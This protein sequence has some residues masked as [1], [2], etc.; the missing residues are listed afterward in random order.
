MGR[1]LGWRC[2]SPDDRLVLAIGARLAIGISPLVLFL[3]AVY[4]GQLGPAWLFPAARDHGGCLVGDA[5]QRAGSSGSSIW[6]QRAGRANDTESC[7]FAANRLHHGAKRSCDGS[8]GGRRAAVQYLITGN[9]NGPNWPGLGRPPLP[10]SPLDRV[11]ERD[12]SGV[13][14]ACRGEVDLASGQGCS[15]VGADNLPVRKGLRH[16]NMKAA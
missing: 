6:P 4:A 16:D 7:A 1:G 9:S 3:I 2:F 13:T 15:I 14:F 8:G 10:R 5:A 12:P 11:H